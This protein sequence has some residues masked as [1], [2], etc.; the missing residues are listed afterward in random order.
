MSAELAGL[1]EQLR[2]AIASRRALAEAAPHDTPWV[3]DTEHDEPGIWAADLSQPGRCDQH[4]P[5]KVNLCDDRP[6]LWAEDDDPDYAAVLAHTAAND[7]ATIIRHCDAELAILDAFDATPGLETA[8]RLLA[9]SYGIAV[10][11]T[12]PTGTGWPQPGTGRA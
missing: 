12:V 11:R 10:P 5:G 6:L 2:A 7:P 3:A 1:V 9:E 8:V 4:E